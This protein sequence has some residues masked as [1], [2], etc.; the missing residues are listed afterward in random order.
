[1]GMENLQASLFR[2]K[3]KGLGI[4]QY[5]TAGA[6]FINEVTNILITIVAATAVIKGSITLGMM[7]AVQFITASL[8]YR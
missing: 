6:T 3:T 2:L 7:L 1:M 8:M 4:I 5:Q